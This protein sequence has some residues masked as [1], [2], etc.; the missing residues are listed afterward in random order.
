MTKFTRKIGTK[1]SSSRK[2]GTKLSCSTSSIRRLNITESKN[3]PWYLSLSKMYKII[4]EVI[5][6]IYICKLLFMFFL[7][8][9]NF[10][11]HYFNTIFKVENSLDLI[12][13]IDTVIYEK[14]LNI[15]DKLH[16]I[17]QTFHI[18]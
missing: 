4:I 1:L 15:D 18:L 6:S 9:E 3:I 17:L 13:K 7:A 8:Q 16:E 12:I 2:I 14:M 10:I 11:I 5:G